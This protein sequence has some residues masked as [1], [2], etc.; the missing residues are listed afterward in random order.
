MLISVSLQ[1][2]AVDFPIL[3]LIACDILAI[4]G[5]SISIEQLFSSSKHTLLD[6]HS[7]MAAEFAP[8]MVVAKE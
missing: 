5:I 2:H 6:F 8:K 4:L 7:A 3:A 1:I